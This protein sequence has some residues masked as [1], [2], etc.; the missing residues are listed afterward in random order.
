MEKKE[1]IIKDLSEI[2]PPKPRSTSQINIISAN[3]EAL[4]KYAENMYYEYQNK[5]DI[6]NSRF[7]WKVFK[8]LNMYQKFMASSFNDGDCVNEIGRAH[9]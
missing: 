8:E 5:G 3:L 1:K 7:F 6:I 9:V 4:E 2:K